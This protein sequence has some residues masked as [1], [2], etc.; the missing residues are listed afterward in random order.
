MNTAAEIFSKEVRKVVSLEPISIYDDGLVLGT[1][2]EEHNQALKLILQLWRSHGLTR[3]LKKG[4]FNLRS[5]TFFGKVFSSAGISPDSNKVA[6]LQ[7][8]GP[9]QSQAEASAIVPFLR[10]S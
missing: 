2:Q 1:T 5:G 6:A 4:Q 7:A 3:N 9:P 10:R 8:A